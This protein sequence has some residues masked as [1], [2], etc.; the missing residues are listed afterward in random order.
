M[1]KKDY[2]FLSSAQKRLYILQRMDLENTAYNM[3]HTIPLS[4]DTEPVK[5]EEALK[6]L[7]QRHESLRT[8]FHMITDPVTPGEVIPVQVVHDEVEFKIETYSFTAGAPGS[9]AGEW[10]A[11]N[12]VRA[13]FFRPFDLS[14][15]PL[16]RA[17]VIEIVHFVPP[18]REWILLVDM[19]HIITDGR[20]QDLLTNELF[21]LSAGESLPPLTLQYKDYAEWR[22]SGKQKELIKQQEDFWINQFQGDI[23]LLNLPIDYPRPLVQS[24]EGNKIRFVLNNDETDTLKETAKEDE[25]TLYITVLSLFTILLSKLSGQDDII[26]GTPIEGRRHAD[27]ESIIGMF[28]NTLAMRNYPGGKKFFREFLKEVKENTL[29]AFENQEYPFEDLVDQVSVRRDAGRNPL[30]DVMFNVLNQ[31]DYQKDRRGQNIL[32]SPGAGE[33]FPFRLEREMASTADGATTSK[34]DLTLSLLDGGDHLDFHIEYCAKLFKEETIKRFIV[35]FRRMLTSVSGNPDP[36]IGDMEMITTAEKKTILYEFNDTA[37]PF[38]RYKTVHEGFEDQ[39][40]KLPDHIILTFNDQSLTYRALNEKAQRLSAALVERGLRPGNIVALMV[41]R[42][43]EMLVGILAIL[44]AGGAYLPVDLQYPPKR[45][46]TML[47]DSSTR[48]LLTRG[49]LANRH[50]VKCQGT[51]FD[52]DAGDIDSG[53]RGQSHQMYRKPTEFANVIYTSGSTGKPKGVM[54]RHASLLNFIKGMTRRIEFKPEDCILSLT[55][56]CFDM[57]GLETLLPL[58]TGTKIIIGSVKEQREPHAAGLLMEKEQV[59]IFQATPARLQSL[60]AEEKSRTGLSQ[61]N[62]LILGGEALPLKLL[63]EA[64]KI[65]PGKIYNGY[66]PT[67]T[68]IFSTTKD[69]SGNHSLNIGKPI[70]NTR[71][72]ILDA[73][74]QLQPM[75]VSGELCIGGDGMAGGYINDPELTAEKFGN[76]K[77]QANDQYPVPDTFLYRTGDLARWLPD[78]N[79]EFLGRIDQQVKVRGFRIEPG[80]IENRLLT[81]ENIKEAVV[82]ARE[83]DGGGNYLTAYIVSSA[84]EPLTVADLRDY[85]SKT[86]PDYMI[87]SYFQELERLPLTP[88]GK[89]DRRA[90]P[91]VELAVGDDYIPPRDER[92][93]KLAA[94]WSEV[95]GIDQNIIG[96]DSNFF[97]LGGHSLKATLLVFKIH[98]TFGIE[99][100]LMDIFDGATIRKL[101]ADLRKGRK[102]NHAPLE[103][104]EEKT[105]YQLSPAQKRLYTLQSM[106]PASVNYNLTQVQQLKGALQPA[107]L[108]EALLEITRRHE[109]LRTSFHLEAMEP[110]QRIHAH[111]PFKLAFL[112]P[113]PVEAQ[114]ETGLG[115]VVEGIVNRFIRPFDLSLVPLMRAQLVKIHHD[116]HLLMLDMH[117]IITDGISTLVFIDELKRLYRGETLPPVTLQYKD[118]S[119][120]LNRTLGQDAL[121]EQGDYWLR[122]F[123]GDTPALNLPTDFPRPDERH[124]KGRQYHFHLEES[125]IEALKQLALA[126]DVTMYMLMLSFVNILLAKLAGAEDITV[127]TAVSGRNHADLQQVVG[128][129]VNT[130]AMRN[131]PVKTISFRRFLRDLRENTLQAFANQDYA[132]DDLVNRLGIKRESNRHPLFDIGFGM[133]NFN[134]AAVEIPGLQVESYDGGDHR[135]KFDISWVGAETKKQLYF[136]IEYSAELFKPETIELFVRNFNTIIDTVLENRDIPIGDIP[137]SHDLLTAKTAMPQ[138]DLEF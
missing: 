116:R 35:Y 23:P 30:F 4:K 17:A 14:Q 69:V 131:F 43:I 24:F 76:H 77:F 11:I 9:G 51:L 100:R 94:L 22:N 41:E 120:W 124:F 3:P 134:A 91:A 40:E 60:L 101:A 107:R 6:K 123:S 111:V 135:S 90:L 29:K 56:I 58:T 59:S 79:I 136:K 105:H 126:E 71:I 31:A 83:D 54:I 89:I 50:A 130:L 5:L 118:Y 36:L 57:F 114:G 28:V 72:Y 122:R 138:I 46:Q 68:T 53:G 65:I 85:L 119:S 52:M 81:H 10:S 115:A 32:V 38:P 21:A 86:L 74:G 63:E 20:S 129:F 98:K 96:I 70:A 55:T 128:M 127:G 19:H 49:S 132:F 26:V 7:I 78:G 18:L 108:E 67:E 125:K 2:Y 66:G 82:L 47:D 33:A 93:E 84:K 92:E 44:K 109:S 112:E 12:E 13:A 62:I 102:V 16:I 75:G 137:L 15:A 95:L 42:S 87:P 27:L 97:Q 45:I 117:H 64:R 80:E 121:A 25:A 113:G 106:E 104:T 48:F 34:F 1:E 73:A 133:E 37:A 110:V 88:N 99:V 8:S 39:V 61:L 103:P